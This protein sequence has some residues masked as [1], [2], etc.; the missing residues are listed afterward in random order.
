MVFSVTNTFVNGTLTDA[1]KVNTN[2]SEI[3][4]EFNG[5]TTTNLV[6]A[7]IGSVVSWL[8][9]FTNTPQTLPT[10]WV[11][12]D[13]AVLSDA[14][15]VYNGQTLPDL[16][17]D[18]SF[19]RGSSTSGSTGGTET[20]QHETPFSG[21]SGFFRWDQSGAVFG[22]GGNVSTDRHIVAGA[23]SVNL[24]SHLVSSENTL[25]TYYEV[26]WIMRIK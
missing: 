1:D 22:T 5:T 25:P 17:G 13:G 16:N 14:D 24:A 12:C 20:H 6:M 19:L 3:V 2:Y 4:D 10:G 7:P 26:V 15:S 9:S 21:Q 8:K 23:S 18:N 11:E